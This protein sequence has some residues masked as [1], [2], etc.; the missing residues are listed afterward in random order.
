MGLRGPL[1]HYDRTLTLTRHLHLLPHVVQLDEAPNLPVPLTDVVHQQVRVCQLHVHLHES[2][3]PGLGSLL[4]ESTRV[5]VWL[6]PTPWHPL[7]L[8]FIFHIILVLA[9]SFYTFID[10]MFIITI[11]IYIAIVARRGRRG[12]RWG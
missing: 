9:L 2:E 4:K 6:P 10:D 1:L 5:L 8:L 11:F 3:A 12:G 7:F